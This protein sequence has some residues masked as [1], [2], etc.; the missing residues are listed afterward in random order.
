METNPASPET[1]MLASDLKAA[2]FAVS[3]VDGWARVGLAS[4]VVYAPEVMA[5]LDRAGYEDGMVEVDGRTANV[6]DVRAVV[7]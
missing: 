4:R 1:K 5:A 7:G 6:V 3:L 2:G